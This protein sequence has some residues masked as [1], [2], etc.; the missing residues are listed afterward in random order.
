MRGVAESLKANVVFTL[1]EVVG[2][3]L[4]VIVGI[5][6]FG[7]GSADAS[8]NFDFKE[9]T[10]VFTAIVAGTTLAFYALIGF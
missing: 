6:A 2:L 7:D 10:S 4:I 1:I 8:R 5:A 3:I 9:G